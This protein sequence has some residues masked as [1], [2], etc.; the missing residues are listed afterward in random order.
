MKRTFF[1]SFVA[2]FLFASF[3]SA[4]ETLDI[5]TIRET[6]ITIRKLWEEDFTAPLRNNGSLPSYAKIIESIDTLKSLPEIGDNGAASLLLAQYCA[7][8]SYRAEEVFAIFLEVVSTSSINES[9]EVIKWHLEAVGTWYRREIRETN[10]IVFPQRTRPRL[11]ITSLVT[12]AQRDPYPTQEPNEKRPLA[13]TFSRLGLYDL[14][15]RVQLEEGKKDYDTSRG[16]GRESHSYYLRA[17]DNAYRAG[18]EELA[19][20]FLMNAAVFERKE[21]FDSAMEKAQLWLDIEAEKAELPKAEVAQGAER[22]KLFLEIVERYQN[23]NAHPRA[24]LFIEEHKNEFDNPAELIKKVHDNWLGV[25]RRLKSMASKVEVYGVQLH[26]GGFFRRAPNPLSVEIPWA[27]PE[28]SLEK[29]KVQLAELAKK[30]AGEE[31]D[32][33]RTWYRN[34]PSMAFKAKYISCVDDVLTL[35]KTDGNKMTIEYKSLGEGEIDRNYVRRRIVIEKLTPEE[36]EFF[37][38]LR[39]K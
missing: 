30:A 20:S 39:R 35:E 22:K 37:K 8:F 14:A 21:F 36:R 13:L 34:E 28:G 19:W 32:G 29:V 17:A 4:S 3:C 18:R 15:W 12:W 27:F 16:Y 24:W 23:M 31:K 1:A 11:Q 26:P 33:F 5:E 2:I 38:Q 9:P 7:C 25:V 6:A 10:D